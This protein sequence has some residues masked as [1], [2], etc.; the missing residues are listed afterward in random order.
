MADYNSSLPIRTE[1]NGDAAVKVVDGTVTS[2]ALEID[3]AGADRKS[4][5]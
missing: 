5:V 1:N 2:Q 3:A 4:V